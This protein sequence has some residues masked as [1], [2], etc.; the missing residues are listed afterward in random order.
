MR[1]TWTANPIKQCLHQW[2]LIQV[3]TPTDFFYGF[4]SEK[5][6][7]LG[8]VWDL[9]TLP[10]T[11]YLVVQ[12]SKTMSF[13]TSIE[14]DGVTVDRFLEY[15]GC[16]KLVFPT[17]SI[18]AEH[19]F[20]VLF[21]VFCVIILWLFVGIKLPRCV[22][23]NNPQHFLGVRVTSGWREKCFSLVFS[24][25][26]KSLLKS[27][28]VNFWNIAAL[29]RRLPSS[30]WLSLT[31][32]TTKLFSAQILFEAGSLPNLSVFQYMLFRMVLACSQWCDQNV[33][34]FSKPCN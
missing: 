33:E 7:N 2:V 28:V 32:G 15:V 30:G 1:N 23:F 13:L 19:C 34:Y 22:P 20:I 8:F 6:H 17:Y 26:R 3:W 4:V 27:Q 16:A 29:T 5:A 21:F 11:F 18:D 24:E 10:M 31:F 25:F 12:K 9:L 14:L